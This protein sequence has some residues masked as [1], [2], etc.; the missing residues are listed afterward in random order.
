MASKV[1]KR[2]EKRRERS[3]NGVA[4]DYTS[5]QRGKTWIA[6]E[7]FEKL[8]V[9]SIHCLSTPGGKDHTYHLTVFVV[10]CKDL[11]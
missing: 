8:L 3:E 10:L 9:H 5:R 11:L 1:Y 4:F 7:E 2:K 6:A